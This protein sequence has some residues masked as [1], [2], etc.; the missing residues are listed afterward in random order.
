MP[1]ADEIVKSYFRALEAGNYGE[2]TKLFSR[3]AVVDSPLY[4][5]MQASE[6]AKDLLADTAKSKVTILDIFESK[7]F[8]SIAARYNYQWILRNSKFASFEGVD[9]F[10]VSPEGL[11]DR[12]KIVYDP[13]QVRDAWNK[14]TK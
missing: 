8:G 2:I 6:W 9:I 7:K 1:A 12:L 5:K 10:Q 11:I 13:A 3:Y 14:A 4:G